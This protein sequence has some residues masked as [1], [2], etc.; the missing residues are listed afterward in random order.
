MHWRAMMESDRE[1][2]CRR[3][4]RLVRIL[5]LLALLGGLFGLF[6]TSCKPVT[7]L[8]RDSLP[9]GVS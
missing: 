6:T 7:D 4:G 8:F 9:R 5:A 2:R 3:L 1:R